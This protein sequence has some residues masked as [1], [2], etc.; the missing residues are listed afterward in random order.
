MNRFIPNSREAGAVAI[1]LALIVLVIG[2]LF[3]GVEMVGAKQ[4]ELEAKASE[5]DSL[6]RRM[7]MPAR[8]QAAAQATGDVFLSGANYAL[9]ANALQQY[10]VETIDQ[11]GGKLLTVGVETPTAE[12]S[13]SRRVMVQ[14]TSELDNDGLQSL[15]HSLE[16]GRPMVLIDSVT[17]RRPASRREGED[18]SKA[19]PRLT[20]ELRV[21]GF[22]RSAVR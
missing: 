20:V 10:V 21:V 17:V 7:A 22:Y 14:S 6:K 5:L 16:A 18:D 2:G 19:A 11:S 3:F 4:I 12:A 13:A 15:L 1:L 9:A 8:Q